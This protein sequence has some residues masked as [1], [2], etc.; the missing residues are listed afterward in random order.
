LTKHSRSTR[1]RKRSPDLERFTSAEYRPYALAIGQVALVWNELHEVLCG[2]YVSL[3]STI[4]EEK[5]AAAWQSLPSDRTKRG[6]LRAVIAKLGHKEERRNP[7]AREDLKW[8]FGQLDRL[9]DDRNNAIHAP[10]RTFRNWVWIT[11]IGRSE[12]VQPDDTQENKRAT[13]LRNK[14]LLAEF[15]NAR[16]EITIFR[17]Y[18]E[19]IGDAWEWDDVR[20]CTWP[21]R[22][23]L[24]SRGQKKTGTV[25]TPPAPP[26]QLHLLLKSS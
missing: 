19:A 25:R 8:L 24:P 22:P 14:E 7:R 23:Q 9:E 15:R 1:R 5:I 17:D 11:I 4:E 20:R 12:G 10:L 26:K 18:V 16:D 2:F 3:V 21:D 13:N 6:M